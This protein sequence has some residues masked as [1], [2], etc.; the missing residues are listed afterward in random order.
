MGIGSMFL[1]GCI[2]SSDLAIAGTFGSLLMLLHSKSSAAGL[3]LQTLI[4]VVTARVLHLGSQYFGIHYRPAELP[5]VLFSAFDVMN[6]SAGIAC[7]LLF[8]KFRTTYEVEKDNFGIQLFDKLDLVPKKGLL[9]NRPFFAAT[10]IYGLTLVL[11]LFWSFVRTTSG[12]WA[13]NYYCCVYEA[14]CTVALFPQLWMFHQDKWVNQL[15]A[16]F[17]VCVAVNR[18]CT[19]TF[20][21][22]YTWVNPWSAPANRTIQIFIEFVNLAVLADFLY[23]WLRAKLRGE[24]RVRIGTW[25]PDV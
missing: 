20:W 21:L 13:M 5:T 18:L 11:A 6:A 10:F 7:I 22:S 14:L 25:Q 19:L 4:A 16:T 2:I 12:S 1:D 17:V 15:L 3:S 9:S 24:T 8:N 23:Y